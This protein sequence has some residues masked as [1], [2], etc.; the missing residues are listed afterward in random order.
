MRVIGVGLGR[1]GTTSLRVALEQLGFGPCYHMFNIVE[2]PR[3]IHHWLDAAEGRP[4][5]WTKV[6]AGFTSVVDFPAAAFWRELVAHYPDAK[7]VLTVRDPQRWYDSAAATI[8][9]KAVEAE[10]RPA[11][12]RLA[13]RL[14]TKISPD[15]GAFTRMVRTAIQQ[16][17]FDGR[18]ADRDHAVKV[19][20]RHNRDVMLEVPADRLLVYDVA[21]GWGPLCS[22][23]GVPVPDGPFP[24]GNDAESF[25][26]DEGRRMRR[27][28]ARS[29]LF[30]ASR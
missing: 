6:F 12:G 21:E 9:K 22:F 11:A 4:V 26:R 13:F 18:V 25:R 29:V 3:R 23:L 24:H 14:A 16:R 1:T 2:E 19:F 20:E 15:L 7:V 17:V 27:M 10:S 8:F 30:R 28:A 5:D